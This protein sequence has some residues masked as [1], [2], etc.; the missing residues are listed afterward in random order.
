[1]MGVTERE[2]ELKKKG[3]KLNGLVCHTRDAGLVL[4]TGFHMET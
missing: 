4:K 3:L 2:R 1:M